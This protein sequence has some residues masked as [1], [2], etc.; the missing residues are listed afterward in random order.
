MDTVNWQQL[1]DLTKSSLG[2]GGADPTDS[3]SPKTNLPFFQPKK[4]KMETKTHHQHPYGTRSKNQTINAFQTSDI[5]DD[6]VADT[7]W[8]SLASS[9]FTPWV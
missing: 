5:N 3:S 4:L 6:N 1:F 8:R 9:M 2:D 7:G